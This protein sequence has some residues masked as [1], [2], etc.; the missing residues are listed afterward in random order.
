MFR[1]HYGLQNMLL[2]AWYLR[3]K[4][5]HSGAEIQVQVPFP[6]YWEQLLPQIGMQLPLW[7]PG[8]EALF[9]DL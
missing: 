6:V 8:M 3:I 1:E 4:H 2:H 5:P 7:K 9:A